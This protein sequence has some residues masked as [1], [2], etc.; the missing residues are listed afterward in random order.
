MKYT[1][2]ALALALSLALTIPSLSMAAPETEKSFLDAYKKAFEAKDEKALKSFL[3]TKGADPGA[4]EFYTMMITA[5]MGGKISS[6]E[7]RDLN[8]EETKETLSPMPMPSGGSAKL[9]INPT[10]KLVL[11]ISLSN[12][13]GSSTSSSESFVAVVDGKFVIPVPVPVK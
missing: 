12:E 5:E 11:K 7:L 3:Y 13:N 4:L 10:K 1:I 6:I 2:T 9:P 8:A